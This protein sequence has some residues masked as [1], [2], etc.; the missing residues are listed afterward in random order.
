MSMPSIF[1]GE[2]KALDPLELN[3]RG[4]RVNT[5]VLGIEPMSCEKNSK[6]SYPPSHISSGTLFIFESGSCRVAAANLEI[7]RSCFLEL[8]GAGTAGERHHSQPRL[9]VLISNYV[10]P[11]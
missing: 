7:S 2:K 8:L 3:S 11:F 10:V 1:G 9:A 5:W 4:L 6:S